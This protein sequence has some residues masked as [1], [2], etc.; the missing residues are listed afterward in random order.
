MASASLFARIMLHA[1][2]ALFLGLLFFALILFAFHP[3]EGLLEGYRHVTRPEYYFAVL[4]AAT[5]SA[6]TLWRLVLRRSTIRE[7][8]KRAADSIDSGE[9]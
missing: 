7:E 8:L 9:A 1:V 2:A 4:A 6:A 3:F 5:I